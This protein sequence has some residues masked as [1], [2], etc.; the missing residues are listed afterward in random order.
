ML[1]NN[2]LVIIGIAVFIYYFIKEYNVIKHGSLINKVMI[3]MILFVIYLHLK[4]DER[5]QLKSK[6]GGFLNIQ[7]FQNSE[8]TVSQEKE[9]ETTTRLGESVLY[10]YEKCKGSECKRSY[11]L[12]K[13]KTD[14]F[15]DILNYLRRMREIATTQKT[16]AQ[17]D[18]YISNIENKNKLVKLEL[19]D[20]P[21]NMVALTGDKYQLYK[22]NFTNYDNLSKLFEII[23]NETSEKT[24]NDT[25]YKMGIIRSDLAGKINELNINF[26]REMGN[27]KTMKHREILAEFGRQMNELKN[28]SKRPEE[29]DKLM[30]KFMKQLNQ[31]DEDNV[32]GVEN[33]NIIKPEI[34]NSNLYSRDTSN[35]DLSNI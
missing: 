20:L 28:T 32:F 6:I 16:V 29:I 25:I 10:G 30:D 31:I 17:I 34:T 1:S 22:F 4:T 12:L 8:N 18:E 11:Y 3:I 15:D 21:E 26:I 2:F 23:K 35:I 19:K 27:G 33:P 13:N 5:H 24:S 9:K 14:T 7:K